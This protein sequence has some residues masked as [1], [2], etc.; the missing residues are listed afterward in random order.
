MKVTA[1]IS[2]SAQLN[3]L[4]ERGKCSKEYAKLATRCYFNE[5]DLEKH[6]IEEGKS[7]MCI[8][9]ISEVPVI[10]IATVSRYVK[11]GNV[12]IYRS[13]WIR[14]LVPLGQDIIE[15]DI[16]PSHEIPSSPEELREKLSRVIA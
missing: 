4:S 14:N 5:E 2:K 7:V 3:A 8:S 10:L 12:L 15:L 1:F 9:E 16:S 6:D 11:T 13:P